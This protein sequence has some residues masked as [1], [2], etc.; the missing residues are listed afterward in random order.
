VLLGARVVEDHHEDLVEGY[1]KWT[2]AS[3]ESNAMDRPARVR[4]Y[5]VAGWTRAFF[6]TNDGVRSRSETFLI[7]IKFENRI[8]VLIAHRGYG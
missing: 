7:A 1:N 3:M 8:R 5:N 4:D 6:R 2:I